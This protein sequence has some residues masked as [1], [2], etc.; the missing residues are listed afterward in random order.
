MLTPN[1]TPLPNKQNVIPINAIVGR[2][3]KINC[4]GKIQSFFKVLKVQTTDLF[5]TLHYAYIVSH[6]LNNSF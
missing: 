2:A 4:S 5:A 3:W 6:L 1:A